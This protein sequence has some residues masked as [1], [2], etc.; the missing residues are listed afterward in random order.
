MRIAGID[1]GTNTILMMIAENGKSGIRIIR[2]EHSIARLG[3]KTDE[4]GEISHA[5][6]DRAANILQ[7]YRNI[8]NEEN[9]DVIL[10]A[11]TSAMRDAK[12][13]KYVKSE[14]ERIISSE[15]RLIDGEEEA[16]LSFLG[17]VEDTDEA[18][19][20]DIGGG[21]TEFISGKNREVSFRKS[22]D[23]GSVRITERFFKN[24]VP[25]D[26][27]ISEAESFIKSEFKKYLSDFNAGGRFYAVA[28]TPTTIAAAVLKL[29]DFKREKI[30]LYNLSIDDI[31]TMKYK[32]L[33][34]TPEEITN[35]Y[36]I[37]P[38][39]AD[40]IAA[41]AVILSESMQY[42]RKNSCIV[43]TMGLRYGIIKDYLINNDFVSHV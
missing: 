33:K 42:L 41:G 8:C 3:E 30:N 24:P 19:V 6:I 9:V 16:R 7:S 12:N 2:D 13:N 36:N 4:S 26:L 23:I 31:N 5:A 14:L 1:I 29:D 22:I 35:Q 18:S 27:E 20:I 21:S 10:P 37:H 40:V 25:L 32:F 39:R 11:A 17:T 43:S 28:G 38:M 15:I 34:M